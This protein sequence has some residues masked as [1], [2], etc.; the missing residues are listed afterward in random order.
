MG[1]LIDLMEEFYAE[2]AFTLDRN[3]ARSAF[4]R[5]LDSPE[6]GCVWIAERGDIAVGHAV[7]TLRY[8]MEHGA[9]CGYIDDLFVKP[10]FRRHGTARSLL[11]AVVAESRRRGCRSI[12]V[13]VGQDNV[14]AIRLYQQMGLKPFQDGRVLLNGEL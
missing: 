10:E 5:L 13:E 14:P 6:L 9:L 7:L 2:S 4:L 11:S 12:Y 1:A 8:T 3:W